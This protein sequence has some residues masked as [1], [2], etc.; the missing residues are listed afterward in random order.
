MTSRDNVFGN[1][2]GTVCVFLFGLLG[3]QQFITVGTAAAGKGFEPQ[4]PMDFGGWITDYLYTCCHFI[5]SSK[6]IEDDKMILAKIRKL[7]NNKIFMYVC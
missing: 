7:T 4:A 1:H 2:K 5:Y 3:V 6:L